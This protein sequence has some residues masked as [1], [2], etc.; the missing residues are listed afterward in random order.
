MFDNFKQLGK[1]KQMKEILE[2]ERG[3]V[4][5]KGVKVTVNGKMEVEE[6][7]LNPELNLSEQEEI[8]KECFNEVVKKVQKEAASKMFQN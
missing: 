3:E 5:I 2:K 4:E 7:K 8:L 1:L 6:I